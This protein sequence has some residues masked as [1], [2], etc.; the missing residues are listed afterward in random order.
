CFLG[1]CKVELARRPSDSCSGFGEA[2]G[3]VP[4]PFCRLGLLFRAKLMSQISLHHLV[5]AGVVLVGTAPRSSTDQCETR[6]AI[7]SS[8]DLGRGTSGEARLPAPRK[9]MGIARW[10]CPNVQRW[11]C[12]YRVACS[13]ARCTTSMRAPHGS[14]I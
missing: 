13:G 8:P 2:P 9:M 6:S 4:R 3:G 14:V 5:R 1:E 12:A 11:A 10:V 7:L